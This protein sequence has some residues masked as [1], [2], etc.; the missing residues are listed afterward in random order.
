MEDMSRA[1][2]NDGY[3]QAPA[4]LIIC[5]LRYLAVICQAPLSGFLLL[6]L[7]SFSLVVRGGG[8]GGVVE[9]ER[10]GGRERVGGEGC[11]RLGCL[12]L[13]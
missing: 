4:N 5:S 11:S 1:M 3:G 6:F 8:V 10:G 7:F 13:T 2:F 9:R 12:D